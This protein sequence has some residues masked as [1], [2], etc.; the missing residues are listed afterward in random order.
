[1]LNIEPKTNQRGLKAIKAYDYDRKTS[2]DGA[3]GEKNVGGQTYV[4]RSAIIIYSVVVN[5]PNWAI[6][7]QIGQIFGATGQEWKCDV[8]LS[9]DIFLRF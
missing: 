9:F 5:K 4:F 7:N 6:V 1:M 8:F 2:Q 3:A